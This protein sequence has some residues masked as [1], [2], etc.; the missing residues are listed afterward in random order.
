MIV[1]FVRGETANNKENWKLGDIFR[2]SP[3]TVPTP[4]A[5]FK[6]TRDTANAFATFRTNNTRSTA[7]GKRLILG[8]ANDGQIQIGR[9]HV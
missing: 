9:A 7:N 3:V 1:G 8:G 5:Y 2:A 4:S 6:D